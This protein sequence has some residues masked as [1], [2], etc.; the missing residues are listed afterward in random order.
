ANPDLVLNSYEKSAGFLGKTRK[1]EDVLCVNPLTGSQNG[2]A[3]PAA[4]PGT[5]VPTAGLTPATLVEGKS[6]ARCDKGLRLSSGAV[7]PLGPFVL[8]GNNYHVYDYALFW[9]VIRRDATTRLGQWGLAR[10]HR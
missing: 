2:S 9:T 5:P 6:G 10:D 7:P 4:N 3:P 8:P 1:R